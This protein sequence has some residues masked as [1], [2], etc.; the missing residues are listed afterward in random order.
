MNLEKKHHFYKKKDELAN[1]L[2][3]IPYFCTCWVYN[4][5]Q[6]I[7]FNKKSWII[8]FYFWSADRPHSSTI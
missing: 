3:K 1:F 6:N 7:I 8:D 4:L 5:S 2:R